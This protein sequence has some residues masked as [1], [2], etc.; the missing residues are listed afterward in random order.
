MKQAPTATPNIYLFVQITVLTVLIFYSI[1]E[2]KEKGGI[3]LMKSG[4]KTKL[5]K[6]MTCSNSGHIVLTKLK[7]K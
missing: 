3:L 2:D 6:F 4:K 1:Y 7:A 5:V